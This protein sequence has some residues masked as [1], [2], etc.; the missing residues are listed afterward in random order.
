MKSSPSGNIHPQNPVNE[1]P[2]VPSHPLLGPPYPLQLPQ[3][4]S[5]RASALKSWGLKLTAAKGSACD[6]SHFFANGIDAS[7]PGIIFMQR[8]S[9]LLHVAYI[10]WSGWASTHQT[11][12][13]GNG[14]PYIFLKVVF[15]FCLA[16]PAHVQWENANIRRLRTAGGRDVHSWCINF[17]RLQ[18][19]GF[20]PPC[21]HP[22][23]NT[24]RSAHNRT[25]N[26]HLR[27]RV[28]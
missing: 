21:P 28:H 22:T 7:T 2:G 18:E 15:L 5:Y 19:T 3:K 25:Q 6:F 20:R 24:Q 13:W 11:H 16:K 4:L 12:A 23:L 1:G 10:I 14:K 17:S 27:K 9:C 8:C 26:P